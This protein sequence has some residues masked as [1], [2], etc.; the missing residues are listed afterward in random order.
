MSYFILFPQVMPRKWHFFCCCYLHFSS[1]LIVFLSLQQYT[2]E[3]LSTA[4]AHLIKAVVFLISRM[5]PIEP[6]SNT[7]GRTRRKLFGSG[8]G[9]TCEQR[10]KRCGSHH[11][12]FSYS[13]IFLG[14][15]EHPLEPNHP[16][17]FRFEDIKNI[18]LQMASSNKCATRV[19]YIYLHFNVCPPSVE[20]PRGVKARMLDLCK[21]RIRTTP[22]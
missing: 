16:K 12:I 13:S 4:C 22:Q 18:P 6:H 8:I 20:E 17:A 1:K 5:L 15:S 3:V 2:C 7:E 21:C 19:C 11:C 14:D 9:V 10:R